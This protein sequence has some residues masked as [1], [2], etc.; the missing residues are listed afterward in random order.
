VARQ[1]HL[2]LPL[3]EADVRA[4]EVGDLVVLDGEIVITAGLPTHERI[5]GC[6]DRGQALPIDLRG[7]AFFHLG[8]YSR[9]GEA[10]FEVLYMNPTTSTRFNP[11]MA[12]FIRHFGLRA[13]G[14]K[15]GLD[16][17]CAAAM[18]EI[19]C[20]YL[21]F[22][23]GGAALHSDAIV[24]VEAVGWPDLVA[25][26]RLVK[27]KVRSLGP[28]TVAIDAHGNSA[29]DQLQDEARRRMPEIL[30]ELSRERGAQ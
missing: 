24:A 29:F 8:S 1:H 12:D 20:V 10:G 30:A 6:I 25:H 5:R 18:Q 27:L 16:A 7:A 9:D 4:L 14:G 26:Y 28:L 2:K 15:G 13:V 21:S 23:G 11:Y 22:L 17:A 19:G 3:S